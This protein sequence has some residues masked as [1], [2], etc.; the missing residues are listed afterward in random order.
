M[1]YCQCGILS[2]LIYPFSVYCYLFSSV[3]YQRNFRI[4]E[5][6][7]NEKHYVEEGCKISERTIYSFLRN[8]ITFKNDVSRKRHL[9]LS[10]GNFNKITV[11]FDL[12]RVVDTRHIR[13]P[14]SSASRTS[15]LLVSETNFSSRVAAV[16]FVPVQHLYR[17]KLLIEQRFLASM[18]ASPVRIVGVIF[19]IILLQFHYFM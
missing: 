19:H 2:F 7:F 10:Y 13:F 17:I 16:A 4:E 12:H 6:F 15:F 18:L 11:P 8:S 1:T 9:S 3:R 5:K 14:A